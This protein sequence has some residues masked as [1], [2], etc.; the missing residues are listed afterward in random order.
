MIREAFDD[1]LRGHP[2]S[3]VITAEKDG[4]KARAVFRNLPADHAVH[5]VETLSQ[6]MTNVV[7]KQVSKQV[8]QREIESALSEMEEARQNNAH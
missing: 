5:M 6:G 4:V 7:L 3:F 1:W 8:A 2:Q